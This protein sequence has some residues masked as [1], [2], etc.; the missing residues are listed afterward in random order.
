MTESTI[1]F[2]LGVGRSCW[3]PYGYLATVLHPEAKDGENSDIA[4]G[5]FLVATIFA[6]SLTNDM[7]EDS[8][9]SIV[10]MTMKYAEKQRTNRI[11]APRV[12]LLTKFNKASI[13][14]RKHTATS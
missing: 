5:F 7:S 13:E 3:I 9:K 14:E 2:T 12:T 1:S 11:W 6:T 4:H 8:W 10:K